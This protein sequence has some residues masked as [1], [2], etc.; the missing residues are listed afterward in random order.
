MPNYLNLKRQLSRVFKDINHLTRFTRINWTTCFVH[1]TLKTLWNGFN[2]TSSC[3]KNANPTSYTVSL[4]IIQTFRQINHISRKLNYKSV[5]IW[6]S[7]VLLL[8]QSSTAIYLQI[9]Y[10]HNFFAADAS[11]RFLKYIAEHL[12]RRWTC[13]TKDMTGKKKQG[14]KLVFPFCV[15]SPFIIWIGGEMRFAGDCGN[16][17]CLSRPLVAFDYYCYTKKP[18]NKNYAN[19]AKEM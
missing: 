9:F 19:I 13:S 11:Q 16:V 6:K 10:I 1:K 15:R 14:G 4:Q 8:L 3:S 12:Q 17:E 18:N 2:F 7:Y 5:A